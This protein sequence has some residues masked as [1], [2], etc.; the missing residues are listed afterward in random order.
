MDPQRRFRTIVYRFFRLSF[1]KKEEIVGHLR[2]SEETDSQLTDVE[3]FKLALTRARERGQV[4]DLAD[5]VE[6]QEKN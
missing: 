6:Q 3:R 1:S 2:L 5:M 4:D